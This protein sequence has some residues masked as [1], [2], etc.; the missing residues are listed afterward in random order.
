MKRAGMRSSFTLALQSL[1]EDTLQLMNRRNMKVNDWQELVQWLQEEG[2]EC[3]AEII[4]GAPGESLESF[5]RGYDRLAAHVSRIAVYPL[6]LLP[7]SEYHDRR[8]EYG[9]IS[10][11]G[12]T[13][14]FG[15]VL[16]HNT[17]TLE[18]NLTARRFVFWARVIAENLVLRNL[19]GPARTL[20]GLTQSALLLNLADW[21]DRQDDAASAPLREAAANATAEFGAVSPALVYFYRDPRAKTVLRRWWAES[22]RPL[23]P[24]AARDCLDEVF[25]YD[26]ATQSVCFDPDSPEAAEYM[27]I[28]VDGERYFRGPPLEFR[29]DVSKL[30][31]AIRRG[32]TVVPVPE[33]FVTS[34]YYK[35]G[36][37]AFVA[38]TNHEQSTYFTGRPER[39][40][41]GERAA[42]VAP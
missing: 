31:E 29:Y 16:A 32:E 20:A 22:V 18:E 11:R 3:Y 7:N 28:E 23:V 2:L 10:V 36:F 26:L 25:R 4:W 38:T 30:V 24:E 14:D 41:L 13:D 9:F 19:W 40:V 17:M 39:D 5:L 27:V 15:Y 42:V 8:S 12:D 34:L 33:R 35:L 37:A 6:L 21:L 1:S